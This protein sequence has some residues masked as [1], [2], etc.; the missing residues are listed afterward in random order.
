M[1]KITKDRIKLIRGIQ[2]ALNLDFNSADKKTIKNIIKKIRADKK[3]HYLSLSQEIP[4]KVS[5]A[6]KPEYKFC[7]D[8]RVRTTLRRYIRRQLKVP[9]DKLSDKALFQ[10]GRAVI[11]NI[12]LYNDLE[13]RIKIL[14]GHD[15]VRHY[16]KTATESC[17]TGDNACYVELYALN[18][19]KVKLVV[20]D[21]YVR[22]LLW[23]CDDG[24]VVLDRIYPSGCDAVALLQSWAKQKGY[25][26]RVSEGVSSNGCVSLSDDKV[27]CVTVKYD[28][29]FP[30]LDTFAYADDHYNGTMTL[31]N[32][33]SFGNIEL[34]ETDG[35]TSLSNSYYCCCCDRSLTD[36]ERHTYDGETYCP[37]C[38]YDRF[39]YCHNCG[40]VFCEDDKTFIGDEVYCPDCAKALNPESDNNSTVH[41]E[42][43]I[44]A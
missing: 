27:H 3:K 41:T 15:I 8:K 42:E 4:N 44:A 37:D 9:V 2:T 10:M 14:E 5:Y 39:F 7:T 43:P 31:S 23:T 32:E 36:D 30:Y 1:N 22:A 35:G 40:D 38:F 17:M 33:Y 11:G 16:E 13:Q 12:T 28:E 34:H 26:Y 19:D 29:Y 21:D 20:L 6:P 24:T 18:P 25:V